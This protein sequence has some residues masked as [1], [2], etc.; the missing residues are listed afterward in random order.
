MQTTEQ[1]PRRATGAG[2]VEL[3]GYTP[4]G[5]CVWRKRHFEF[6]EMGASPTAAGWWLW[7]ATDTRELGG[8]HK[9]KV[10]RYAVRRTGQDRAES[11]W[12]IANGDNGNRYHLRMHQTE[13]G[14]FAD[15]DCPAAQRPPRA[16]TTTEIG[17]CVHVDLLSA[18]QARRTQEEQDVAEA[19]A[20][21]RERE[22]AAEAQTR[23]LAGAQWHES[24]PEEDAADLAGAVEYA[25][26]QLAVVER[27]IGQLE[28]RLKSAKAE[29]RLKARELRKLEQG[30]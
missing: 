23:A 29:R 27:E 14:G 4:E 21:E 6:E 8:R 18:E 5:R 20:E 2:Q 15:C 26:E 11:T 7:K 3:V 12:V 16:N 30:R 22:E 13:A 28:E 1:E 25:R 17:V 9:D 10:R 19:L 24:T